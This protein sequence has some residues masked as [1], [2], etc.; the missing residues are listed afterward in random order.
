MDRHG[1][2]PL[3]K[4][5]EPLAYFTW[6][7]KGPDAYQDQEPTAVHIEEEPPPITRG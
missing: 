5:H 2:D 1:D 4:L 3:S 7:T 6:P